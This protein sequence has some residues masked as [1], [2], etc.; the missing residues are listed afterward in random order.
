VLPTCDRAQD[1]TLSIGHRW[2]LQL[3]IRPAG[4]FM[5]LTNLTI[6]RATMQGHMLE[7][8]VCSKCPRLSYLSLILTYVG[9]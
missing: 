5:A 7:T 8:L 3:Q 6:H 2:R 4:V 9:C 1:I